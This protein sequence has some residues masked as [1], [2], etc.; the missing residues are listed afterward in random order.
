MVQAHGRVEV[1]RQ[2]LLERRGV[3]PALLDPAAELELLSQLVGL[4]PDVH[5]TESGARLG[6]VLG[7]Q[8][9]GGVGGVR[10]IVHP[11]SMET[12]PW[13]MMAS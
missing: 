5:W 2:P 10:V 11:A 4:R 13:Q 6:D 1:A 9:D 3:H 7:Q 8:L 12:P